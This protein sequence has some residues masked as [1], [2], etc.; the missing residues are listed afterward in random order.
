MRYTVSTIVNKPIEEVVDVIKDPNQAKFWMEGL[1]RIEQISG[2]P[3]EVGSTSELEFLM[4][5]RHVEM[6]ETV[7]SNTLPD[8]IT[9]EYDSGKSVHNV[10]RCVFEE[11]DA[12]TTKYTTHNLFEFSGIGMKLMGM[13]FPGMFKKQSQKYL[14]SFKSYVESK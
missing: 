3:G 8:E 9:L 10:V 13:I 5:K 2:E 11:I 12:T 6:I 4:G 7:I 1:Q 14:D